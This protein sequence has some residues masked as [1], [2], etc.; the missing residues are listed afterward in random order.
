MSSLCPH[1]INGSGG[2]VGGGGASAANISSSIE[3]K[4]TTTTIYP[5]GPFSKVYK[6]ECTLCTKSTINNDSIAT[7]LTCFNGSCWDAFS[8]QSSQHAMWHMKKTNHSILLVDDNELFCLMCME[9][10]ALDVGG[11]GGV[12]DD[13]SSFY[14]RNSF[15]PV[16]LLDAVWGV[17]D[18]QT[19]Q[20]KEQLLQQKANDAAFNP[21][22]PMCPH[23]LDIVVTSQSDGAQQNDGLCCS[24]CK[25][26]T[27]HHNSNNHLWLCLT[28]GNLGCARSQWDGSGG[29][30]HG[31][32]HFQ[33]NQPS[34]D[35]CGFDGVFDSCGGFDGNGDGQKT[36]TTKTTTNKTNKHPL[37]LK[38]GTISEGKDEADVHCYLCDSLVQLPNLPSLLERLS[39]LPSR[40]VSRALTAP[41]GATMAELQLE[42]A[43]ATAATAGTAE[44]SEAPEEIPFQKGIR[45]IKNLGNSCYIS[46]VLQSL[47]HLDSTV[48]PLVEKDHQETCTN[49]PA[50]CFPCQYSKISS[51]ILLNDAGCDGFNGCGGCADENESNN[52]DN[53]NNNNNNNENESKTAPSSRTSK[54]P[55]VDPWM[56]KAM[57]SKGGN[58]QFSNDLQQD[59]SE[60]LSFVLEN[61]LPST[62]GPRFQRPFLVKEESILVCE[63]CG[64]R[65]KTPLT[66]STTLMVTL[67]DAGEH[68]P[69]SLGGS[70]A[71]YFAPQPLPG[72]SCPSCK[73]CQS[74]SFPSKRILLKEAPSYLVVVLS[75]FGIK[76]VEVG[77]G[78]TTTTFEASK[79]DCFL[80]VPQTGLD[81]G[82]WI[83]V[84]S[85]EGLQE[86][87]PLPQRPKH[88]SKSV[89]PFIEMGFTR[90]HCEQALSVLGLSSSSTPSSDE[91]IIN[92][93]M[94][95][96]YQDFNILKEAGFS[97][98]L[99]AEAIKATSSDVMA[100]ME[101]CLLH[102]D[103][104][105]GFDNSGG[106]DGVDGVDDEAT[107]EATTTKTPSTTKSTYSLSSFISH[108][109][110]SLNCG[111]Y[112]NHSFIDGRWI[113][114][115]DSKTFLP[116]EEMVKE[117][118]GRDAYIYVYKRDL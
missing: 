54:I 7:C 90:E 21:T 30:G 97:D 5:P 78:C 92:Y 8:P 116:K 31:L 42:M 22:I 112:V 74:V 12:G 62:C 89:D 10:I 77:D 48:A 68:A 43:N 80:D 91:A 104:G 67:H 109:G 71:Q 32:E 61:L 17:R 1:L 117:A 75:R 11:G 44:N 57:L 24:V 85:S 69:M 38:V 40:S 93:L 113:M 18:S 49:D 51:A 16:T 55:P 88:A 94:E 72:W 110:K 83:S 87:A 60:F 47:A 41:K 33:S 111:H 58:R 9:S 73:R 34:D 29:K 59:A 3:N 53:S 95:N 107:T 46:S 35:V 19:A 36:N 13:K 4:S 66:S 39:E 45:G 82:D 25:D 101:Y 27:E 103:D 14:E 23:S 105:V 65:A 6:D 15:L 96:P 63:H 118:A 28:C 99:I 79:I 115:N 20:R 86:V 100:A 102:I 26:Q 56:F 84:N 114:F 37:S 70:L 52:N 106:V 76:E 81:I 98:T 50:S 2:G 64:H 108:K